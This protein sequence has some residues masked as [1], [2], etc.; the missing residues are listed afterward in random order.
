M[1]RIM[2]TFPIS[3][4]NYGDKITEALFPNS[5]ARP[6]SDPC[7]HSGNKP[8]HLALAPEAN[9]LASCLVSGIPKLSVCTPSGLDHLEARWGEAFLGRTEEGLSNLPAPENLPPWANMH[10]RVYPGWWFGDIPH[11]PAVLHLSRVWNLQLWGSQHGWGT[12]GG[13]PCGQN[14]PFPSARPTFDWPLCSLGPP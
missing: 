5:Q 10:P 9:L 12:A 1:A 7:H 8:Q 14:N 3:Q 2:G 11:L 13:L 6:H 4:G